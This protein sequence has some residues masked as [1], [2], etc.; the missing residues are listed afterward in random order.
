MGVRTQ[1]RGN[2]EVPLIYLSQTLLL[3]QLCTRFPCFIIF[4]HSATEI[5]PF[6]I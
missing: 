5:G 4:A 1:L 2:T 6:V 3:L